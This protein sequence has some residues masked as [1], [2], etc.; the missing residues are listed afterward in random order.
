MM[1]WGL[2]SKRLD[3]SFNPRSLRHPADAPSPASDPE[4]LPSDPFWGLAFFKLL[5]T[6]SVSNCTAAANDAV[7]S[8]MPEAWLFKS[9]TTASSLRFRFGAQSPARN[10]AL[11]TASASTQPG[12]V[13]VT[14]ST[15][16]RCPPPPSSSSEVSESSSSDGAKCATR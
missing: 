13:A 3:I 14:P 11:C 6:F 9:R 1:R 8:V 5:K 2:F 7:G 12:M 15:S 4:E 16:T 10:G